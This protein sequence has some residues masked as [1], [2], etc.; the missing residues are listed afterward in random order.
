MTQEIHKEMREFVESLNLTDLQEDVYNRICGLED[1]WNS[2]KIAELKQL[3]CKLF[4]EMNN[5]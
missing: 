4:M 1:G 2:L 5:T 3:L